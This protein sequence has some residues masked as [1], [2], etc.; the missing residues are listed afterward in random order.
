MRAVCNTSP[1]ILLAKIHRLDLLNRLYKQVI[2]PPAALRELEAK[3]AQEAKRVRALLR[4][5]KFHL[6]K[7]SK[8]V[9]REI[10]RDLGTGEREAIALALE[11]K[12]DLV[13]LDDQQGRQVAR[14]RGLA[15]TGTIGL[16]IEAREQGLIPSIRR[17]LDRLIEAGIWIDERFYHR[18]LQEFGE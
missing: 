12:A 13:I 2:I 9:L 18:I 1:L 5:R 11:S 3:P 6:Q 7:A 4:S 17:E 10:P 8:R 14:A 16:L 15:V